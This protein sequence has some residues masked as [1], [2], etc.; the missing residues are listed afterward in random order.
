[1]D[2]SL[3]ADETLKPALVRCPKQIIDLPFQTS[4]LQVARCTKIIKPGTEETKYV[5]NV[6]QIAKVPHSSLCSPY[7]SGRPFV[8]LLCLRKVSMLPFS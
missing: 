7:A 4:V 6:K 8:F 2:L 1:M 5:I 3:C